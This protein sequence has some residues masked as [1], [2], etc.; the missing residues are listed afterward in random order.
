MNSLINICLII[1]FL[2]FSINNVHLEKQCP[3]YS[4][5]DV[6]Y[7]VNL[8]TT[9]ERNAKNFHFPKNA[10]SFKPKK[11]SVLGAIRISKIF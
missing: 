1:L 10:Y 6:Q 4:S 2:L 8:L 3:G 11:N 7:Y 5:K 9:A